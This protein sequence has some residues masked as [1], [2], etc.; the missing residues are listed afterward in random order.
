MHPESH[1]SFQV[2]LFFV[3]VVVVLLQSHL[4]ISADSRKNHEY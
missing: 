3:V 2:V 1:V 4:V